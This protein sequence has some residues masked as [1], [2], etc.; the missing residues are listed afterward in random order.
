MQ[1]GQKSRWGLILQMDTMLALCSVCDLISLR[2]SSEISS[3]RFEQN[4]L[5]AGFSVKYILVLTSDDTNKRVFGDLLKEKAIDG[6]DYLMRFARLRR[7]S[8]VCLGVAFS[9]HAF[10][11]RTLG[12]R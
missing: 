6:R 3:T 2:F 5:S 1:A 9:G 11:N 10:Q 4:F 7:L 8:E 12:L